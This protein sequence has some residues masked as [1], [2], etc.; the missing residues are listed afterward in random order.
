MHT[1]K[2]SVCAY[3]C[4]CVCVM[5]LVEVNVNTSQEKLLPKKSLHQTVAGD[6]TLGQGSDVNFQQPPGPPQTK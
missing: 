1:L 4:S 6:T 5:G 2:V 3:V